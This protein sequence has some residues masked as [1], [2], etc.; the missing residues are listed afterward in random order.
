MGD[1]QI[2]QKRTAEPVPNVGAVRRIPIMV[3]KDVTNNLS[4]AYRGALTQGI[5]YSLSDGSY[6]VKEG[7]RVFKRE[8]W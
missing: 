2:T 7:N 4:A 8:I 3:Y 6:V 5:N 1:G